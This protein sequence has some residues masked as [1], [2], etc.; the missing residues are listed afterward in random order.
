MSFKTRLFFILLTA[1]LAGVFSF[2]LVDL[3]ALVALLPAPAGVEIPQITPA[4]KLLSL[5]QPAILLSLAVFAGVSLAHRVGLSSP[6]AEALASGNPV[7]PSLKP[8]ILPGIIGGLSGGF[9]IVVVTLLAKPFLSTETVSRIFE[10]GKLLPLPARLLYGG[11]TEELLLRWGVMTLLVWAAWRLLQRRKGEPK[12]A[13]FVGAIVISS[14]VFGVGHL[15]VAYLIL[16]EATLAL[17]LYVIVANSIFGL[18]AGYLYWK[19]GLESA[20]LAHM[21]AHV[22]MLTASYFGAYY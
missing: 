7:W 11:I 4:I 1:G 10:F 12:A 19:K 13:W 21:L 20:M 6:A 15:P 22:V 18:I 9:A 3:P 17:T 8:Q 16:P 2:L 5:I 14:L